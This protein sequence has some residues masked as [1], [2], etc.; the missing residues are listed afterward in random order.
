MIIKEATIAKLEVYF[1]KKQWIDH[2]EKVLQVSK[3]G[4]GNMN[5]VVRIKTNKQSFICKQSA[6]YVEKYPQIAAPENRVQIE[7]AFYQKIKSNTKLQQM[8]PEFLGIDEENNCMILEDLGEIQDYTSLYQLNKT[9]SD[10]ELI[11]L[12]DYLNELHQSFRKEVADDELA[13]VS[14]KKLNFEH[15]FIY[16]FFC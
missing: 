6:A 2:D 3:A 11:S 13:N 5:F 4:D 14:L 7:A 8:M 15:I 10:S 12:T 1:A 9:M 16:P